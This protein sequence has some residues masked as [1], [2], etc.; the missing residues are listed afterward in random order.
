L[1]EPTSH[2]RITASA[3]ASTPSLA[4]NGRVFSVQ[5]LTI[6]V[7]IPQARSRERN[8][9]ASSNSR[10]FARSSSRSRSTIACTRSG[11]TCRPHARRTSPNPSAFDIRPSVSAGMI[12]SYACLQASRSSPASAQSSRR[13]IEKSHVKIVS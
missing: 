10:A 11:R 4:S 1:A 2:D 13:C 5:L 3:S 12:G 8:G 7:L 9:T 6:A